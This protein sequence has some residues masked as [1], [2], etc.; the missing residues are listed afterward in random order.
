[1]VL[2]CKSYKNGVFGRILRVPPQQSIENARHFMPCTECMS[3]NCM[4][5]AQAACSMHALQGD[6]TPPMRIAPRASAAGLFALRVTRRGVLEAWRLRGLNA[7]RIGRTA[8][9]CKLKK[10]PGA[11]PEEPREEPREVRDTRNSP[12]RIQSQLTW[13]EE[14]SKGVS[15]VSKSAQ[16]GPKIR[17]KPPESA[18]Q[19]PKRG[20]RASQEKP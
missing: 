18:Q 19:A 7:E 1:M 9:I 2:L 3:M 10:T 4:R 16:R 5:R 14:Q 6:S 20:P 12:R 13:H 8:R 17:P 15:S 11:A